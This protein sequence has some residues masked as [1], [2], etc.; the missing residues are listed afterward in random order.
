LRL[1][2]LAAEALRRQGITRPEQHIAI[3]ANETNR[4]IT[5]LVARA[6]FTLS[7]I[8]QLREW[9]KSNGFNLLHD[10][11]ERLDTLYADYLHAPDPRAFEVSYI[12]NISPVTDDSPFYY[13]YFKW[14]NLWINQARGSRG[15]RLLPVGNLI[16]L[17]MF[18]FATIATIL[19]VGFP[20]L[21]YKR[22]GLKTPYALPM[23]AYFSALGLGYIFV[24]I[25][26]IQRFTLFI[27]YPTH[28]MTTTIFSMLSFSAIGSLVGQRIC[29]S[30]KRLQV[31]LLI[32]ATLILLYIVGLPP[33]FQSLLKLLD[34]IRTLLSIVLIAPLAFLMGMPFPTGLRQL[35][36][37]ARDLVPWAWGMNGVFS[38]LGS[39]LVILLSM[40]TSFTT[41]LAVSAL[42]YSVA[43]VVSP[44]LWKTRVEVPNGH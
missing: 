27:G 32:L 17:T 44:S 19:F 24:E 14:T 20:L 21:H 18:G 6:P 11:F 8:Q 39:V 43:A 22:S 35:G 31:I 38:V 23:L 7:R 26:L 28:A 36:V 10:P 4:T 33:L 37:R 3:V 30:I 13:N 25:V 5:L 34:I 2:G 16:L 9:A 40:S 15:N 41:A 42:F 1:T 29:N 12:F